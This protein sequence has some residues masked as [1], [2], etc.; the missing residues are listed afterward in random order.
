MFDEFEELE[1]DLL[2]DEPLAP[3][4]SVHNLLAPRQMVDCLGHEE[5]EAALKARIKDNTLPHALIF[6]GLQ[7]IGKSTLAFRLARYLFKQGKDSGQSAEGGL[8]GTDLPKEEAAQNIFVAPDESVFRQ[9]ASGGHP[10]LLTIERL[11]DDK[12]NR[13]KG[14]VEVD[15][16]RRITPFLRKTASQGGWRVVIVDD[17]DTMNRSSQNAILKILEEPPSNALLILV[18]HRLGAMIPTIRSR[19][20]TLTFQPLN[21]ENFGTLIARDHGALSQSDRD[22][23][24]HISSGSIGQGIKIAEE[25]GLEAVSK[26][27]ALFYSWPNWQW[28]QIHMLA[29]AMGRQG[30]EESLQ[31]FQDVLLWIVN[32]LLRA[33]ARG[34]ILHSPLDNEA[35][36]KMLAHYSLRD[37]IEI[38]GQLQ[39]HF[40][41][42]SAASLDKRHAVLGAFS[43]FKEAL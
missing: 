16:I 7:G 10:D 17:A 33:K 37:W 8:F 26:I 4:E 38:A 36:Q 41:T 14:T 20:R 42:V 15:E 9:V 21:R 5:I 39:E 12:K 31:A 28:S 3:V 6:S 19:C 34:E 2:E 29:E 24:F 23:L 13:Y 30:Q 35:T 22:V 18:C 1:N 25:G 11:F 27:M 43:F 32:A 40:D